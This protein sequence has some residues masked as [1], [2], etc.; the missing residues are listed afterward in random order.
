MTIPTLD[1]S[2]FRFGNS[3]RSTLF[4]VGLCFGFLAFFMPEYGHSQGFVYARLQ[5]QPLMNTA[6]W[7]LIG[8]AGIGDTNGDVDTFSNE[9]IL[10]PPTTNNSGGVF[11]NQPLDLSLCT[12]WSARFD[13]RIFEGSAADGIAFCFLDVP[14][15]NFVTGGG[16]GIPTNGTGLKVVFDTWDNG[17][18]ANPEIQI[19][20]GPGYNECIAGIVKINNTNGNLNFMRSN[21]YHTAQVDYD[22]GFVSVMI[23]SVVW[24]S[25]VYAPAN[26]VGYLGFTSGTGAATDR[27]S[28]RDVLIYTEG[29]SLLG[30]Q[31]IDTTRRIPL[32]EAECYSDSLWVLTR[33]KFRCA[34]VDSAGSDLRLYSPTGVPIPIYRVQSFCTDDRSDSLL[35]LLATRLV[36][37]GDHHLVVRNGR[38][39]NPILG[40]CNSRIDE[41]DS[42]TIRV[43]NCYTYTRPVD[44]RNVSV[45]PDNQGVNLIWESPPGI[46]PDFFRGYRLQRNDRPDGRQWTDIAF[47]SR[48][49]DTL[50]YTEDPNPTRESR[51]FRVILK[52]YYNPDCAPGDSVGSIFLR[53][54]TG[55][56]ADAT[57]FDGR[58]SW[59][60]YSEAWSNPRYE[61]WMSRPEVGLDSQRVTSTTDTFVD[62]SKPRE[63]GR[64]R[65]HVHTVNDLDGRY[66]R[67][68]YLDFVVDELELEVFNV[69]TPN[70][71]GINDA[72]YIRY[73]EAYPQARVRLFNRWGQSVFNRVAYANN[74]QPSDL[75]AGSYIYLIEVPGKNPLQGILRVQ[76]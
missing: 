64:F 26:Y 76:R 11:Y 51:D 28:I 36:Q 17:C 70:G 1:Y 47:L 69:V 67:S 45:T 61:I 22:S 42:L 75:E 57:Q 2:T 19:Y 33:G 4:W 50:Y 12:R 3:S 66:A 46:N 74:Y 5:G 43:V 9:M 8:A 10:V 13:F 52:V 56:L 49:E 24:L 65:L 68:N 55:F 7:S 34:S 59:L 39:G 30:F 38:D 27:H 25:G 21:N 14:P 16:I 15:S 20:S 31:S 72:F 53:D 63:L 62:F 54:E 44:M 73:I 37:P 23:D 29:T 40:D 41:F 18:G 32:I 60:P 35:L 48:I 6:G 71:D 58:L